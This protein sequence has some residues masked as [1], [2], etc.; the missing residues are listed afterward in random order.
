MDIPLKEIK[1]LLRSQGLSAEEVLLFQKSSR[2]T[3]YL[4][5]NKYLIRISNVTLN[6]QSRAEWSE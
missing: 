1:K 5:D 4:I 2:V 6:E 3:D